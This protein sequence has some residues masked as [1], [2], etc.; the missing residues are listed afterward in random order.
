MKFL[1]N[2]FLHFY[3]MDVKSCAI[4]L[5]FK[6]NTLHVVFGKIKNKMSCFDVFTKIY[7]DKCEHIEKHIS[8]IFF[9]SYRSLIIINQCSFHPLD[10]YP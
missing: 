10:F 8:Y 9:C 5:G 6:T 4:Q 1:E 2:V 3:C 7:H